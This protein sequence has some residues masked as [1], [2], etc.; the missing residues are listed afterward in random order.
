MHDTILR[1]IENWAAF[2]AVFFLVLF[3]VLEIVARTFFKTGVPG[4]S[5]YVQHLVIWITFLGGMIT[6]REDRHLSLSIG[7]EHFSPR[8]KSF[9]RT[10]NAFI[11]TTIAFALAGS[12]LSFILLAFSPEKTVGIIP[13]RVATVILPLGYCVMG[14]RFFLDKKLSA[15]GRLFSAF[16]ILAGF[17]FSLGSLLNLVMFLKPDYPSLCDTLVALY[18][19]AAS[20][21]VW[22]AF[23]ILVA[24]VFL[25]LPLFIGLGGIA[26]ILLAASGA[27]LEVI[28][29]EAYTMLTGNSIAAIPLF[30]IA[31][32][33]LSESKAGERLVGLFR[34]LFGFLP[35]GLAVVSV[36]VCAF[37]TT[38][39]GASGVTI[40]ALGGLL[41]FILTDKHAYEEHYATGLLTASGS[42]GL[43]FPPSLPVILYGVVAGV[44]IKDMFLGGIIPGII[45]VVALS[46]SGVYSA[47]KF[48]IPRS[49]F[50]LKATIGSLKS[51]V[52]EVLLPVIILV[53]YFTGIA[54]LVETG[55][56]AVLYIVVVE[57]FIHHDKRLKDLPDMVLKS[58][59]IIGGVLVI[60]AVARGLSYYI[61][62]ME[63]PM[64]L[65]E[66]VRSVISSR[67]VFLLLLNIV[68]LIT[69]C[70]MDIYSAI[71]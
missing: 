66:W 38:F 64:R 39:T 40:L 31:G 33:V 56:V 1:R 21:V 25:G 59:P 63:L 8:W 20:V 65:T 15:R 34:N 57:V 30:T 58:I 36:L 10:L 51:S 53:L 27:S 12:S 14:V 13:I 32:F 23:I 37:F 17:L 69:G 4:S 44:S 60:L 19:R 43:L 48:N 35:G 41:Y 68:L 42:I 3:S 54:T 61:I 16:G 2:A 29:N 47:V 28:P 6:S 49:P 18:Y 71:M 7:I 45:M 62:D 5:D 26:Y 55:A 22:P 11:S 50:S 24:S 52:W 9:I 70:L 46:L 67:F